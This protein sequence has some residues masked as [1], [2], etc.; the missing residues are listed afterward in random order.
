M[1]ERRGEAVAAAMANGGDRRVRTR[2]RE[3][4]G[5]ERKNRGRVRG[6]GGAWRRPGVPGRRGGRQ[7]SREA[8]GVA[9]W[10]ARASGTRPSSCRGRCGRRGEAS[11]LRRS[12]RGGRWPRQRRAAAVMALG[13]AR[14]RAGGEEEHGGK[15]ERGR[16]GEAALGPAV[17]TVVA[18]GSGG[19]RLKMNCRPSLNY[20]M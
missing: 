1:S 10:R 18:G 5:E 2:E 6:Y 7:A 9:R 19:C 13:C 12:A 20:P 4:E 15:S 11:R 17:R 16:G 14:E 8:G 3:S